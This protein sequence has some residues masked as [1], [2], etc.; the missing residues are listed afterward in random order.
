[1]YIQ[2]IVYKYITIYQSCMTPLVSHSAFMLPGLARLFHF[3]YDKRQELSPVAPKTL[4]TLVHHRPPPAVPLT[5]QHDDTQCSTLPMASGQ[6]PSSNPQ[7]LACCSVSPTPSHISTAPGLM[8]LA[9]VLC[10]CI[11][12]AFRLSIASREGALCYALLPVLQTT[13]LSDKD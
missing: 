2:Y 8:L 10:Y 12:H 5:P 13:C 6:R 1:M 3:T 4:T 11:L 9:P 7:L